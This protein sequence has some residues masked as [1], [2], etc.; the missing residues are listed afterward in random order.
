MTEQSILRPLDPGE[1]FFFMA[2]RISCMNFVV[3][4]ERSG[5]LDPERIRVGLAVMQQA[6]PLL[7]TRIIWSAEDGLC[8][9][10]APGKPITLAFRELASDDWQAV[11]ESELAR[12]F[13]ENEAPL[14][15]CLYLQMRSPER[16]VLALCFHHS[17]ADGRSGNVLLTGLIDHIA[18][19]AAAPT[20]CQPS[21][22]PPMY[23]MFPPRFR[24]AEQ[25][26]TAEQVMDGLMGDYKRHGRLTR[27]PWL[28]SSESARIPRFIRQRFL[29]ETT[30]RLLNCCRQ[31]GTSVHG[32]VC[33]AQLM[34]QFGLQST[35]EPATLFLSCPVDMRPHLEPVQPTTPNGLYV[36]LISAA[37][38]VDASTNL[39]DLAR[40]VMAQTKRQLERGE[41][42]LFFSMYGLE[43]LPLAPDQMVRF[44]KALL[45]TWQNTMVS[46]V[47]P[48]A[49]IESDPAVE[50]V[51]FALCPMPYQTLFN[52]VSTYKNQLIMNI[53][54]DAGKVSAE[55]ANAIA[56]G[57]RDLLL[58]AI[59][60]AP[61]S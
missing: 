49:T 11:I 5:H 48:V 12:P 16:S 25:P 60:N 61:L 54:Y 17:I 33:A 35:D 1:A 8:F 24:W 50:A 3:L 55:N 6:N 53:G 26:D 46:N 22:L 30:Q 43:A 20:E 58:N 19:G 37:F 47:G 14:I 34:A 41:G 9:A 52:A 40:A 13:G 4:A 15:R 7:Q 28:S 29:P 44:S 57:M 39:W 56:D 51:S 31:H 2:D 45:S 42:H 10:A 38:V 59:G 27:L 23:A 36:S 21:P 18:R 32:A